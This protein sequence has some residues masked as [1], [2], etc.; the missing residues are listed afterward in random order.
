M[1][2]RSTVTAHGERSLLTARLQRMGNVSPLKCST[3]ED[4]RVT[5]Q[6]CVYEKGTYEP[7]GRSSSQPFA[8]DVETYQLRAN[9]VS[10]PCSMLARIVRP[11][12]VC[13]A[14]L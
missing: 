8:R 5:L 12:F 11:M 6:I 1:H 4:E 3:D 10:R 7:L 13:M 14:W 2:W 9:Y